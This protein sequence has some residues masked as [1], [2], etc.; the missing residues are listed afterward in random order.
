MPIY[1]S[2]LTKR[3][4]RPAIMTELPRLRQKLSTGR[5]LAA[6]LLKGLSGR[7]Q[8]REQPWESSQQAGLALT[9]RLTSR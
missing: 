9:D 8:R 6:T 3:L 4:T 7:E 5:A 1:G 2:F